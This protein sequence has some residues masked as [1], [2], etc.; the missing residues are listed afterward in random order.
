MKKNTIVCTFLI[1]AFLSIQIQ[2]VAQDYVVTT[3]GDT[4]K[5]EV[6]PQNFGA[7]S[8]VQV[9]DNDKNKSSFTLFQVKAFSF[10]G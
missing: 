7:N 8:K 9:K 5:G 10:K 4:L 3:K 1:L 2:S 6:K